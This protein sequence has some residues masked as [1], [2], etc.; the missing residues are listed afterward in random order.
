MTG[1]AVTAKWQEEVQ[2]HTA[3]I[4][5]L[6]PQV[7]PATGKIACKA[8]GDFFNPSPLDPNNRPA[9]AF[10][11]LQEKA[12]VAERAAHQMQNY[13]IECAKSITEKITPILK[14]WAK[15]KNVV[16]ELDAKIFAEK[17]K[18]RKALEVRIADLTK[19]KLLLNST[20][21]K[22]DERIKALE[23]TEQG[24]EACKLDLKKS[25]GEVQNKLE[26]IEGL[27]AIIKDLNDEVY[28]RKKREADF[29]DEVSSLVGQRA[30]LERE[31]EA[32]NQA[33]A[34][35]VSDLRANKEVLKDVTEERDHFQVRA[36]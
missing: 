13:A 7:D 15:A 18:V 30:A 34:Q 5:S 9:T 22:A 32:L 10:A 24:L 28:E 35:G 6:L 27:E 14:D 3:V 26:E 11:V 36:W 4:S 21:K 1:P 8:V 23:Y 16:Y 31:K 33:V 17:E 19:D 29:R 2:L 25:Q 20:L 12:Q